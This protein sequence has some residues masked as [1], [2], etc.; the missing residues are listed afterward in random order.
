LP[1]ALRGNG[2]LTV[3][4]N[5]DLLMLAGKANV[6][7]CAASAPNP[8][9][10]LE[11]LRPEAIVCDADFPKNIPLGFAP[12]EGAIFFGGLGQ[13][14]AGIQLDPDL[15]GIIYPYPFLN[16]AHG[17]LLEGI[18]LALEKRFE[19]FSQGRGLITP[20]RVEEIWHI[21]RKH[22]IGLPPLFNADG[23]VEDAISRLRRR[24]ADESRAK[25]PD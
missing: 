1:R 5:T 18:T 7:V 24:S 9:N 2:P 16:V 6:L 14:S 17:C 21:A 22:G 8:I 13:A 10:L 23:P 11:A 3:E 4:A 12:P 25:R 20:R 19:P 15:Q